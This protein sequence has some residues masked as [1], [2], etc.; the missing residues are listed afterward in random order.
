MII[1]NYEI[2]KGSVVIDTEDIIFIRSCPL[3]SY[4][5]RRS[6]LLIG[7][8][9]IKDKKWLKKWKSLPKYIIKIVEKWDYEVK[10][11]KN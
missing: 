11:E 7:K 6:T 2:V 3:P 1:K 8:Y 4:Q 9:S 10:N 5:G